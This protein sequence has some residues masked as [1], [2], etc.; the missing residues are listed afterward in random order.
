MPVSIEDARAGNWIG[1]VSNTVGIGPLTLAGVYQNLVRFNEV[2]AVPTVV[3]YSIQNGN[4]WE[5]GIANFDGNNVIDRD[6]PTATYYNGVYD[7][8][9][10]SPIDLVGQSIVRCSFN[11]AGF[12]NLLTKGLNEQ[13]IIVGN[14]SNQALKTPISDLFTVENGFENRTDSVISLNETTREFTIQ[15]AVDQYRFWS[16]SK[17]FIKT[18]PESLI[19]PD[20]E[21][22]IYIYFD[23][24]SLIQQTTIFFDEIITRFAF[25]AVIDWSVNQQKAILVGDERHG[26]QMSSA[27]HLYNHHTIGARY[28]S[29]FSPTNVVADGNG[30]LDESA[31]FGYTAGKFWDEDIRHEFADNDP[32]DFDP[33]IQAPVLYRIGSQ[34]NWICKDPDG[35]PVINTGTGR[36][37]YNF[38]NGVDWVL[39]EVPNNDFVLC[40]I[41]LT[42]DIRS[43]IKALVGQ[44]FYT[45]LG[46]AKDGAVEEINQLVLGA[47]SV[48]FPEFIFLQTFIFQTSDGYNN[49]VKG[50][51]RSTDDGDF[52]DWRGQRITSGSGV[53]VTLHSQLGGLSADD[54]P[55]YSGVSYD[56]TFTGNNIFDGGNFD[57]GDPGTESGS[58]LV[59]GSIFP[60]V[61][62]INRFGSDVAGELV[63]H[64]HSPVDDSHLV[65]S[66][67]LSTD[68]THVDVINGTSLGDMVFTGWAVN[69]YWQGAI[70]RAVVDGNPG[71]MDMPTR[72]NF[73]TS[74]DGSVTPQ[75]RLSIRADGTVEIPGLIDAGTRDVVYSP[76]EAAEGS[77]N[78]NRMVGLTQAEYDVSVKD[79]NTLYVITSVPHAIYLGTI[80]I[81]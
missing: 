54:H 56:N 6:T 30:D 22:L 18:V 1:E 27:T 24:N 50:R 34:G 23:Q 17:L 8:N 60:V 35:F 39:G 9:P 71:S 46:N 7:N 70:I 73:F 74:P 32:Q 55:Q 58:I 15:P 49:A 29:G 5:A 38:F 62:K 81:V 72:I 11:E 75:L 19:I 44:N 40:H 45:T 59:N 33:I 53:G 57:V 66:R 37:A 69:S 4:N 10:S 20:Q 41:L 21:E 13:N 52:Q 43:P 26:H 63:L 3:F 61:A 14:T 65:F 28:D 68:P 42:N 2:F 77:T 47:V 76:D 48:L 51:I 12:N 79:V 16:D 67:A 64:R 31:Q 78:I 36:L 80:R 25:V